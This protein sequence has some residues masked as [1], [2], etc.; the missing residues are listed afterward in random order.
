MIPEN[1]NDSVAQSVIEL[2]DPTPPT[3]DTLVGDPVFVS[4]YYCVYVCQDR[5]GGSRYV[6]INRET[7]V[8]EYYDHILPRILAS[9]VELDAGLVNFR[10][11][12]QDDRKAEQVVTLRGLP[13]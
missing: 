11:S 13:N 3:Q 9:V 8:R 12:N 10:K 2:L 4:K 7:N 1:N 5:F 6:A